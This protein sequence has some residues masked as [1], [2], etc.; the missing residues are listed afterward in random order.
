MTDDRLRA[1]VDRILRELH[2]RAGRGE[3][4]TPTEAMIVRVEVLS[5]GA[6]K[7][8]TVKITRADLALF[9]DVAAQALEDAATASLA[10]D[11]AAAVAAA[12][13]HPG[14]RARVH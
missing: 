13:L 9:A 14:A 1:R 12:E 4:M 6:G 3:L 2:Q 8:A 7:L 11:E 10:E 5:S